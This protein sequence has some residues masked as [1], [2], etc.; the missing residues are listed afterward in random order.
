MK[1]FKQQIAKVKAHLLHLSQKELYIGVAVVAVIAGIVGVLIYFIYDSIPKIV[2]KPVSACTLLTT[3]E[4]STLLG[5]KVL[6]SIDTRP[7]VSGDLAQSRCG[8]T[9]GTG[10]ENTLVVAAVIVRSAVNDDGVTQNRQDFAARQAEQRTDTVD[11]V[12][13]RAFFVPENGQLN[14]LHGRDWII[15]SY[16]VGADPLANTKDDALRLAQ[17]VIH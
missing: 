7:V 2:Y 3:K 13:D 1:R 6:K 15:V 16:G 9:N 5:T 17:L 11:A 4:A 10:D 8:Y 12:G 14:V